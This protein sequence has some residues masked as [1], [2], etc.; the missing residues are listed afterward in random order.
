MHLR[1]VPRRHADLLHQIQPGR[2][3]CLLVVFRAQRGENYKTS[4]SEPRNFRTHQ[5]HL[6]KPK[7]KTTS[8]ML[9]HT[10]SPPTDAQATAAPRAEHFEGLLPALPRLQRSEK[11]V[12]AHLG[13]G[14]SRN[15]H[16]SILGIY[17]DYFKDPFL[18]SSRTRSK[19]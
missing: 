9:P 7:P 8:S 11:R 13:C 1:Y 15:G 4:A 5:A 12:V 17:R 3:A 18:Y 6:R 2:G 10:S 14:E 19:L 16:Y